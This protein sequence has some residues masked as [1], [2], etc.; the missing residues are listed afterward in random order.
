MRG[1]ITNYHPDRFTAKFLRAGLIILFS[2]FF[3]GAILLAG[4]EEK[5]LNNAGSEQVRVQLSPRLTSP[6]LRSLVSTYKLTISADDMD[7]IVA[8]LV[9]A[10]GFVVG[11]V[12]N[13]PAG[14]ERT[15]TLE[16]FDEN[17]SLIY[18]GVTIAEVVAGQTVN[19]DI[20]LLP[21]VPLIR[22]SPPFA[23]LGAPESADD[24]VDLQGV[25][26]PALSTKCRRQTHPSAPKPAQR[27]GGRVFAVG[28]TL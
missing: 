15:F 19:V 13:I 16:C 25:H 27:G 11:V 18:R 21:V 6:S 5:I 3:L 4:C 26:G 2:G 28:Q 14:P 8:Q 10:E 23:R 24:F 1:S 22:I 20:D 12:E 7:T 9:W 17:D